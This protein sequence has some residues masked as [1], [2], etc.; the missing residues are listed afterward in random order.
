MKTQRWMKALLSIGMLFTV[1][2]TVPPLAV[3]AQ[4]Q[5][6]DWDGT[7]DTSWYVEGESAFTID[8]AEELAGVSKLSLEENVTFDGVTLR[9]TRDID[10][11]GHKWTPIRTFDG[12][13]EGQ[14]HTVSNMYVEEKDAVSGF[15]GYL[16]RGALVKDLTVADA[17]VVVPPTNGYFYQGVF[18]GWA[19]NT[20]VINCGTSGSLTVDASGSDVP[21]VGGFIGS[22]KGNTSLRNCW[23]FVDVKATSTEEPVMLGGMVGQWENAAD[24]AEMVDCY[25]GGSAEAAEATTSTAGILGAALSF[26][27]EVVLISGCVSYGTLTVPKGA[28]ENAV[29]IAALDENGLAQNCLWPDDGK[30]GVVRLVVDWGSGTAGADPNF[31]ES[32]CGQK[33]TDFADPQIIAMLNANAQT[34]NLWTLGINGYPVFAHQSDRIL[35]DYRA[36]DAAREQIPEDLS[37]YTEASVKNLND[38]LASVNDRLSM[39]EQDQVDAMAKAIEDAIAALEYRGADYTAV[40]EAI[41]KAEA[42]DPED[43]TDFSA[44]EAAI[45]AVEYDKRITEQAEVD[46]MAKAIEDAIAALE[47]KP[48]T[49]PETPKDPQDEETEDPADTAAGNMTAGWASLVLGSLGAGAYL[50]VRRRETKA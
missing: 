31:D 17:E 18:A 42:L 25:F 26:N 13:F 36:I 41:A 15:F 30:T 11:D 44:V 12:T 27:G 10:L 5:S 35:A 8:S 2:G 50:I 40:E 38:L 6:D 47:K 37:L 16:S 7:A 19:N 4:E 28:E 23:S 29:H 49:V 24:G 3:N 34:E 20:S 1:F 46:A 9:L 33:V 22:C 32:T 39:D 48:N 14:G 45:E 43:Y 21:S